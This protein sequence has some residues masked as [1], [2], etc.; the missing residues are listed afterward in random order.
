MSLVCIINNIEVKERL[1]EGGSGLV[2][3]C[4]DLSTDSNCV[5]KILPKNLMDYKD[6]ISMGLFWEEFLHFVEQKD[7]SLTLP[8]IDFDSIT[9]I[10]ADSINIIPHYKEIKLHLMMQKHK[11]IAKIR[12]VLDSPLATFVIMDYYPMDLFTA[13]IARKRFQKDGAAIKRV[14][15]QF[16]S[17]L[18]FCHSNGV[19]HCDIKP[20]NILLDEQDNAYLC[21]F[22]LATT[23]PTI[24]PNSP[25]GSTYY[26]APER[27]HYNPLLT[28]TPWE[29]L[30]TRAADIWSLGIV[31]VNMTCRCN[32]WLQASA[33]KD[34]TFAKF[35][36]EPE[37]LKQ[38][39]PISDVV[40]YLLK[41]ILTVD[42]VQRLDLR[43]IMVGVAQLEDFTTTE[44]RLTGVPL[45]S[46]EQFFGIVSEHIV[47]EKD[48]ES[49]LNGS[50]SLSR[51]GTDIPKFSDRGS[52]DLST[53]D[54]STS[55]VNSSTGSNTNLLLQYSFPS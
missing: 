22:G 28:H 24:V 10:N 34:K 38:I 54:S 15:L 33:L 36:T 23:T 52:Q 49:T 40:F 41:S 5:L 16:C 53:L 7:R 37:I 48:D 3:R 31:L 29:L 11:H 43:S 2:F 9:N 47:P 25:I 19:Y 14:F 45:L 20:E 18:D 50:V 17:A 55:L 46:D 35:I 6:K 39:L 4:T 21:D 42:P 13:I 1:D 27:I 44:A 32:P 12:N 8:Q 51:P 26:I 30:E